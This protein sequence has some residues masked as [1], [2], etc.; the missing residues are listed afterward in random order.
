LPLCS[1]GTQ[2]HISFFTSIA[3][4]SRPKPILSLLRNEMSVILPVE[5]KVNLI[6]ITPPFFFFL[7]FSDIQGYLPEIQ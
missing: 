2:S 5:V 4:S 7:P 3:A 1:P 6:S